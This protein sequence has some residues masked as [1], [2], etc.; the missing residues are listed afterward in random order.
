M[1]TSNPRKLLIITR[2]SLRDQV[3]TAGV[4]QAFRRYMSA[5]REHPQAVK[6]LEQAI[7]DSDPDQVT[8]RV[9]YTGFNRFCA[10]RLW[11]EIRYNRIAV[12]SSA[13]GQFQP[14]LLAEAKMGHID[15]DMV[16]APTR[17]QISQLLAGQAPSHDPQGWQSTAR[18]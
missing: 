7:A 16:A 3:S 8:E 5:R 1:D 6:R 2:R 12:V 10:L 18:W 13:E 17:S 4:L 9:A 14:E 15:E 11:T